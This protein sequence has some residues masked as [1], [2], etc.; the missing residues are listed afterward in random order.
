MRRIQKIPANPPRN[1]RSAAPAARRG[2]E[3]AGHKVLSVGLVGVRHKV[4][5]VGIPLPGPG[6]QE[7]CRLAPLGEEWSLRT[8]CGTSSG[9]QIF[10]RCRWI[11]LLD[12][13][14]SC[15]VSI[16]GLEALGNSSKRSRVSARAT[17]I[18]FIANCCPMQFLGRGQRL[19][20]K[21]AS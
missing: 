11:P 6:V 1:L 7:G 18:S 17:F 19:R 13:R 5:L 14:M 16:G 21:P 3:P 20:L 8:A 10:F 2:L 12:L 4:G 9:Q 15:C